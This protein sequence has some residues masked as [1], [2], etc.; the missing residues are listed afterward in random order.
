MRKLSVLILS[1]FL[2]LI[3]P[4]CKAQTTFFVD[5]LAGNDSNAGNSVRSAWKSI[6]RLNQDQFHPG[7]SILFRR[8]GKWQENFCPKGSGSNGKPIVVSAYGNGPL[9]ELDAKG[10]I[11]S[12]EKASSTIRLF[13]QEYW[14]FKYLKIKNFKPFEKPVQVTSENKSAWSNSVKMGILVEGRDAGILHHIHFTGLEICEVNGAMQNKDNG[15]IFMDI[16]WS[17]EPAQRKQTSFEDVI[18]Q[19][20]YIHDVD[21]TGFSNMSVWWNRSLKSKWGEKLA[22]G[23]IDNW[24]PSKEI[25]IRNN[26]FERSGANALIVRAA[27]HPV[28]EYNLFSHCA[29]K[30]SGNASFPFNCDNAVF[31]YNEACFTVYNSEADS[32]DGKKD[33]DAGGFDSDW[34]CKNT[35][36]Q[37]NYSHD[38]GFGG[39][40]IC[41]DGGSKVSFN[42]GT[43]LRY[44]IFENNG[45]HAIRTSGPATNS[46]V[47]NNLFYSGAAQDS[48]MLIF[49]KSWGGYSDSTLYQNNI[50]VA[51]GKGCYFNTGK[52][53]RNYFHANLFHGSLNNQPSDLEGI[54]ANPLF[55]GEDG[56]S[57]AHPWLIY[58]LQPGSPA[59]H[60]GLPIRQNGGHDFIG[61]E[62]NSKPNRGPFEFR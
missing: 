41:C 29:V 54:V 47:Y 57:G 42:D 45:D 40:L 30:G 5:D 44:N 46:K 18:L 28:I 55:V 27:E 8:G 1:L 4:F 9:P 16:S 61:K 39:V 7:D 20:C 51:R 56:Q 60:S 15:G 34:N 11:S 49:H 6:S 12:G 58:L 59:I 62:I 2:C 53:T 50:F 52:S 10:D 3:T 21:R 22:N 19:D 38:N 37:Y 13:N 36:I 48:V 26:R 33:A 17:E 32:W 35:L 24:I 31:Q 14:E 43:V 23:K 25:I